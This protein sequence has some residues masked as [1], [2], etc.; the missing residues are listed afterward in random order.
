VREVFGKR[1][2]HRI[3]G[4]EPVAGRPTPQESDAALAHSVRAAW[5]GEFRDSDSEPEPITHKRKRSSIS[6]R[7][8]DRANDDEEE[9]SRYAIA[10]DGSGPPTKR[11]RTGGHMDQ[12][13]AFTTD[14][15]DMELNSDEDSDE[16]VASEDDQYASEERSSKEGHY[17]SSSRKNRHSERR[18]FWLSKGLGRLEE[19]E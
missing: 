1:T 11:R 10:R 3:L 13:T 9:E 15:D 12:H 4:V 16:S 17:A 6:K 7:Q 8:R 5:N 14:E 2:L 18:S 19:S